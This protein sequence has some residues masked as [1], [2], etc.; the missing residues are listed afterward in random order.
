MINHKIEKIIHFL[1]LDE[2]MINLKNIVKQILIIIFY[3]FD[4]FIQK[5]VINCFIIHYK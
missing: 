1:F 4:L 5:I 3:V 2:Q